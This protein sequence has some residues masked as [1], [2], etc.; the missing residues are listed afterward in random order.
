M[1]VGYYSV[2]SSPDALETAERRIAGIQARLRQ[3]GI[4]QGGQCD[5]GITLAAPDDQVAMSPGHGCGLRGN[6]RLIICCRTVYCRK[7]VPTFR[8]DA[9]A[10]FTLARRKRP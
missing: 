7:P 8:H 5:F 9:P 2:H 3:D 1:P 6:P 4:L 10:P